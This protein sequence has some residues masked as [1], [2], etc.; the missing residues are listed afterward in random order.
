MIKIE[1]TS[2]AT[3]RTNNL[4]VGTQLISVTKWNRVVIEITQIGYWEIRAKTLHDDKRGPSAS[5]S[6]MELQTW[7]GWM[8]AA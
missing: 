4:K 2:A 6:A 3:C 8:V 1:S 7:R 5:D